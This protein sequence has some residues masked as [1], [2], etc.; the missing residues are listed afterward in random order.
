MSSNRRPIRADFGTFELIGKWSEFFANRMKSKLKLQTF[1]VG[2]P[3]KRGQGL[4]INTAR[5]PPRGVSRDEWR[6]GGYFDS[7][8]PSLAPS[9]ALLKRTPRERFDEPAV[10]QRFFA[11]YEREM[12][13]TE[14]RQTIALLAELA[15]RIPISI[16]CYCEDE[17]HCHRSRLRLLIER[18]A[19][20]NLA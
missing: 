11:A 6:R 19:K 4:R 17:A 3:A 20:Q 13:A 18:A 7:W 12:E 2:A 15:R 9:L 16:G 1:Q 8:L 10:R 5:R 14:P